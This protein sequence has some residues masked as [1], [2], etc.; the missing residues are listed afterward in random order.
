MPIETAFYET[1]TSTRS[2]EVYFL[3]GL[4]DSNFA[5]FA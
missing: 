1:T 2:M 3:C 4:R 5:A